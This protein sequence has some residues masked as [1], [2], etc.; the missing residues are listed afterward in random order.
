VSSDEV[1]ELKILLARIEEKLEALKTGVEEK[2]VSAKEDSDDQESRIR[3]LERY[4]W[5]AVGAAAASGGAAGA[6]V[7]ALGG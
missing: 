4:V 1:N 2:L 3:T 5:I 6:L 7:S